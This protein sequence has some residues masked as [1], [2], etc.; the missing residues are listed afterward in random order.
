MALRYP[1]T[2]SHFR[3]DV[4]PRALASLAERV[5][6]A[7]QI[8]PRRLSTWPFRKALPKTWR[9]LRQRVAIQIERWRCSH[10]RIDKRT[11]S[12]RTPRRARNIAPLP[13][14]YKESLRRG[15]AILQQ[16]KD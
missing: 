12:K 6:P 16:R 3:C 10:P 14:A 11:E 4:H 15:T 1:E 5:A 7:T 8:S 13:L 2:Y 9:E